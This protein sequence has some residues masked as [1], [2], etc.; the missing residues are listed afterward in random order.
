MKGFVKKSVGFAVLLGIIL[1]LFTALNVY[2]APDFMFYDDLSSYSGW[3]K[4]PVL[5]EGADK[6]GGNVLSVESGTNLQAQKNLTAA[7]TE[8]RVKVTFDFKP[9]AGIISYV[10]LFKGDGSSNGNLPIICAVNDGDD[11]VTLQTGR[12]YNALNANAIFATGKPAN[13]WY[14]VTAVLNLTN[15][16]TESI[17]VRGNGEKFTKSNCLWTGGTRYSDLAQN[18]T[19]INRVC[20]GA[21]GATTDSVRP[22]LDN[23]EIFPASVIFYDDFN[24]NYNEGESNNNARGWYK[25]PYWASDVS[26]H[27]S[28]LTMTNSGEKIAQI[29]IGSNLSQG[30]YRFNFDFKPTNS[31]SGETRTSALRLMGKNS[32]GTDR[33]F[34]LLYT[35]GYRSSGTVTFI[36]GAINDSGAQVI[37]SGLDPDQWFNVDAL[38]DIKHKK[39]LYITVTDSSGTQYTHGEY[40]FNDYDETFNDISYIDRIRFVGYT[41]DTERPYLDNLEIEGT[42]YTKG[43][44]TLAADGTVSVDVDYQNVTGD[45]K[46]ILIIAGYYNQDGRFVYSDVLKNET[47][48]ANTTDSISYN[49]DMSELIAGITTL[50]VFTWDNKENIS[51]Y[52]DAVE[53]TKQ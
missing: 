40:S 34:D 28:A 2:A 29:G 15:Q 13:V 9:A 47:V 16:K 49:R 33:T 14:T 19:T 11:T 5:V 46:D 51:A 4:N 39:V 50:K 7:V 26:G 38:V 20:L 21:V 8:G 23:I 30:V 32:S 31:I 3:Y 37:Q 45:A 12:I 25:S 22:Y 36:T 24:N 41:N 10:S 18:F 6:F 53:I 44:A 52:S 42:F 17:E 35:K 1:N 27:S 43:N 48:A